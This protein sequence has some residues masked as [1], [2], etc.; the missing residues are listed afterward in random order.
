MNDTEATE[1]REQLER[2]EE[3]NIE[4]HTEGVSESIELLMEAI[5]EEG[6]F[7]PDGAELKA[8]LDLTLRERITGNRVQDMTAMFKMGLL[9]GTAL[10]RDVPEDSELEEQWRNGEFTLPGGDEDES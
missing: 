10:E 2:L 4:R 3:Q 9:F 1:V 7:H 6:E 8:E 5:V